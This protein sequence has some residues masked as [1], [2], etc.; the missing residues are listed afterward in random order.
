MLEDGIVERGAMKSS[1][2]GAM[3]LTQFMPSE[4]FRSVQDLDGGRADLFNSVPDA[5][6]SA[7]R[8]LQ[9]KGW[10][11]GLPWGY[12]VR[13][14]PRVDC[15]FEGPQQ[16]RT[17]G[18]WAELGLLRADGKTFPRDL[19]TIDAYLM[20]PGGANGPSFLVTENFKVIRRYNTS[21][22]YA[23]FVGNL[24]DRIAGGGDFVTPWR[25]GTAQLDERQV[26][27]IQKRLKARGHDIE[28]FD[29]KIG[30]NTR[31]QIGLYQRKA[32]IAVDCWPT[33]DLLGH[34]TREAP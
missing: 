1:W 9:Q 30:S 3:G 25:N 8:Q 26:V 4:F 11:A 15:G 13:L 5:L 6:A 22:L 12:E 18:A 10:V 29:G 33:T 27:E 32:G 17:F 20:S 23:V 24:A 16:S 34:L 31:M 28:K 19:E 7:A 21:D 2:A 14:G